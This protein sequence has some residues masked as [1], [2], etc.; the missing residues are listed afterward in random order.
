MGFT[1]HWN[2]V[3]DLQDVRGWNSN[4]VATEFIKSCEF[5]FLTFTFEALPD[6]TPQHLPAVV[7]E[8]G[9]FV[10]VDVEG[11]GSDLEVLNCGLS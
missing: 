11:M 2:R 7:A 9:G 6:E 8:G 4:A 10:G 5:V 1:L 3:Q